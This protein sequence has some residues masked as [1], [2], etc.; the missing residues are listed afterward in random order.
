VVS[1]EGDKPGNHSEP[2]YYPIGK[3]PYLIS[4]FSLD[5]DYRSLIYIPF[6]SDLY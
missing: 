6:P 4:S 5:I 3:L 1:G 2:G